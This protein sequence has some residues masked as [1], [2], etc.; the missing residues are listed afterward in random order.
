MLTAEVINSVKRTFS[1][2]KFAID[3]KNKSIVKGVFGKRGGKIGKCSICGEHTPL[4]KL[5][6][7]HIDPIVD[8][9]ISGRY[10]S[11]ITLYDRTF[12]DEKNL[13]VL[14]KSCHDSKSKKERSQRVK[15]RKK[16]KILLVRHTQGIRL[17][18]LHITN[19]KKE[20]P[21]DFEIIGVFKNNKL[22]KKELN[23][24]KKL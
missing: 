23:R 12:C 4:Y 13:Q 14:C 10:M 7:D 3:F 20:F 21:I 11:F 8:I 16:E 18:I 17:Q 19:M 9:K 15:W 6:I 5:S 2:S 22:A 24:R 1:R